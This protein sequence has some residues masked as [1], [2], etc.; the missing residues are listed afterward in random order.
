MRTIAIFSLK[1]GVG[2]TTVA[3]NLAYAAA[4]SGARR[5]LLWDLDA[6]GAA[7]YI[8]GVVERSDVPARRLIGREATPLDAV[9]PTATPSLSLLA[10]DKS[11]RHLER[12]LAEEAGP[13]TFRKLLPALAPHFDRLILDCPPG[14]SGIAEQVFRAANIIVE[15]LPPAPLAERAHDALIHHLERHHGGCPPVLPVFS[16]VDARR[17]LHRS[18]C[19]AYPERG[20]LPY[21]SIVERMAHERLPIGAL[22]PGSAPAR[23]FVELWAATER[24]LLG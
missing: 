21:A 13:G 14:F 7:S 16:M 24:H 17:N 15:P 10:A 6:Q 11:L 5:T 22:A 19:E 1:G 18:A 20:I 23:A 3:V 2:K 9:R 8:L 12:Q 4:T